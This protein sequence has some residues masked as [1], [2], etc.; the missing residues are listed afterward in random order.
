MTNI[1]GFYKSHMHINI[2]TQYDGENNKCHIL[3]DNVV[4]IHYNVTDKLR[5]LLYS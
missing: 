5:R 1:V 3:F 2:I 4:A